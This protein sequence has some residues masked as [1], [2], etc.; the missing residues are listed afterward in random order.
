MSGAFQTPTPSSA[1]TVRRVWPFAAVCAAAAALLGLVHHL[2]RGGVEH[3]S[4][5]RSERLGEGGDA[6]EALPPT[7]LSTAAPVTT[8]AVR[9]GLE[10]DRSTETAAAA[11]TSAEPPPDVASVPPRTKNPRALEFE[12]RFGA[13]LQRLNLEERDFK[14]RLDAKVENMTSMEVRARREFLR[15]E[16]ERLKSAAQIRAEAAGEYI[17][18]PASEV[19]SVN[20]QGHLIDPDLRLSVG[21]FIKM[22]S[23]DRER[24]E[25]R[26]V[27]LTYQKHPDV[28]EAFWELYRL[29][30]VP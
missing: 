24:D 7:T 30:L 18:I 21:P 15:H 22:Y 19:E 2:G 27:I 6:P 26:H 16:L 13:D 11:E 5:L 4:T 1:R 14:L 23:H 17:V 25:F 28:Y 29:K 8:G 20:E 3:P 10:A 12:A 9:E